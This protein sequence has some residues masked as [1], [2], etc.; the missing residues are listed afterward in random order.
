MDFCRRHPGERVVFVDSADFLMLGS[1]Q[2]LEDLVPHDDVLYHGEARCW[3]EPHK[4]DAYPP[5]LGPYR[6][7][8]GTGPAGSTDAIAA[9]IAWIQANAPIRG[10]EAS[11]FSDNDQRAYTDAYLGGHGCVDEHGYLSVQLNAVN[12]AD[13]RVEKGRLILRTGV[14]PIFA[15]LNGASE[16]VFGPLIE[17]LL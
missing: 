5:A 13:V 14:W 6:F 8:N 11:I 10:R 7:V 9:T 3:P 15:H 2:E 17:S 1:R 16:R 12:Q 4:L